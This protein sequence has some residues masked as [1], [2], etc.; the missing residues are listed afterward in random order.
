MASD[1]GKGMSGVTFGGIGNGTGAAGGAT[2]DD[3]MDAME[4]ILDGEAP[5]PRIETCLR[6]LILLTLIIM[7]GE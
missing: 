3:E 4:A 6:T 2:L 7:L 1:T 5:L